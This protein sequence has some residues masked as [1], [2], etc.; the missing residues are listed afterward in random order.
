MRGL[1]TALPR[2]PAAVDRDGGAVILNPLHSVSGSRAAD[3]PQVQRDPRVLARADL[4]VAYAGLLGR[5]LLRQDVIEVMG[6]AQEQD[7]VQAMAQ[8]FAAHGLTTRMDRVPEAR[9]HEREGL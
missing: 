2:N 8:A 5:S 4:V 7:R 6:A 3:D 9:P 1:A